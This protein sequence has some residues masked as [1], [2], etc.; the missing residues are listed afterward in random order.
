MKK[1][2]IQTQLD[3]EYAAELLKERIY[4]TLALIAV[5]ISIDTGH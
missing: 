1:T 3:R 4:A 2:H 5:L